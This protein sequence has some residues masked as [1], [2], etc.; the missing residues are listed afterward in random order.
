MER[1]FKIMQAGETNKN[2]RYYTKNV[3]IGMVEEGM[4]KIA[5]GRLVGTIGFDNRMDS[6]SPGAIPL[7][8]VSHQITGMRWDEEGQQV[9]ASVKML[10]TPKGAVLEKLIDFVDG[11]TLGFR[12][13]GLCSM[14]S[15]TLENGDKI[16]EVCDY[17]LLSIDL[18][19]NPA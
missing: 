7:T 2:G 6:E 10:Q 14:K 5:V 3:C 8:E 1:E 11:K 18:V 13:T 12:P 15:T 9:F 19:N 4:N 16:L 17:S